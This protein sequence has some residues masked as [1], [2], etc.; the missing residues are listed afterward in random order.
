M[1]LENQGKCLLFLII[2][3]NFQYMKNATRYIFNY[4]N[5]HNYIYIISPELKT[6]TYYIT[7][8]AMTFHN[9]LWMGKTKVYIRYPS[10][11]GPCSHMLTERGS[12][13]SLHSCFPGFINTGRK[14]T[15]CG[16]V[17]ANLSLCGDQPESAHVRLPLPFLS[18][19][20]STR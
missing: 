14:G 8:E 16:A 5:F 9:L 19:L 1:L 12:L 11:G 20:T 7:T 15:F 3:N 6:K 13:K 2:K 4:C 18:P 10:A 17:G